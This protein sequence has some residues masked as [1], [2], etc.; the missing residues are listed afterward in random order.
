MDDECEQRRQRA[1]RGL[2]AARRLR[3]PR[4]FAAVVSAAPAVSWTARGRW[5]AVKA[6]WRP[7]AD[8]DAATADE[9]VR[10]G[11]TMAKRWA[12]RSVDRS[13]LKRIV[14]E[15][16][17]H[18]APILAATARATGHA[19]DV[20]IRLVAA[21]PATLGAP[22]FRR[23]LRIEVDQLL[24][25]LSLELRGPRLSRLAQRD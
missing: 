4:E 3:L 1:T 17:R 13:R 19:V 9:P 5:F 18:A 2:P 6:T 10:L 25:R 7:L 12:K 11:I 22:E 15:S 8:L 21:V 20:S 24:E 23:S 14:R 16:F